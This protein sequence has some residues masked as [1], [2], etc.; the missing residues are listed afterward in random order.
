MEILIKN[1]IEKLSNRKRN[2]MAHFMKYKDENIKDL[3]LISSGK[4]MEI[5]Y[6]ISE[7]KSLIKNKQKNK[8]YYS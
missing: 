5:D 4:L 8:N 6:L 7:L 2:E 1:M 3:M